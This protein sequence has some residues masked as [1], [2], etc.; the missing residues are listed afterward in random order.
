MDERNR[1]AETVIARYAKNHAIADGASG[2][3]GG[4]IPIPGAGVAVAMGQLAHQAKVMYP[5]LG[6]DLA[7]IYASPPDAF[8]QLLK[9]TH[10]DEKRFRQAASTVIQSFD[11][12]AQVAFALHG[13]FNS[14]FLQDVAL[15]LAGENA[16]GLLGAAI[17]FVG[18]FIGGG[19]DALIAVTMTWRVGAMISIHVQNGGFVGSRKD[20]WN[21][22]RRGLVR[23]NME[24]NRPGLLT[25]LRDEVPQ[26]KQTL[27]RTTREAVAELQAAGLTKQDAIRMLSQGHGAQS[28]WCVPADLLAKV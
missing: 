8:E 19:L 25:R 2:T 3:A 27:V 4:L 15:D 21:L 20:T 7:A 22:V 13:E 23:R 6:S 5:A 24:T 1:S 17:P 9:N 14:Q 10:Q 11:E 26:V 16:P 18:A 28:S 12:V